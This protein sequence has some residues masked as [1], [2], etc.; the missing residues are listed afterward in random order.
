MIEDYKYMHFVSLNF[1]LP[2]NILGES[3]EDIEKLKEEAM[4]YVAGLAAAKCYSNLEFNGT[5]LVK[6]LMD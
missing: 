5:E 2:S 6:D 4:A 1:C 3:E